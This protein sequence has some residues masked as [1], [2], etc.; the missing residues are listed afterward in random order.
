MDSTYIVRGKRLVT[1][2]KKGTIHDGA[3]AIENGKIKAIG[4]WKNMKHQY[5]DFLVMDYSNHVIT[6]SLVDCHTHLLEFAPTS[7]YPV[8]PETHFHAGRAILL[9]ALSAGITAIGE[10]VCGHPLC[11][12]S[13][14]DYR[15]MS[16]DFPMD[17]SFAAASISIG[18]EKLA[19]FASV[20]KSQSLRKE[21]LVNPQIVRSIAM[22]SD[23]PGENIFIN[24]TPANFTINEV[25]RA[26]EIIYSLDE[27]KQIT[28]I[29]HHLGKQIGAHVAGKEGIK[30]ALEAQIDVCH[31]VHGITEELMNTAAE[32]GTKVVA[33]PMG[34]THLPPNA[35]EE[36]LSLVKKGIP[37]SI[38]TDAYLPPY[39]GTGWLPFTDPSLKGPDVLML[40]ASPSMVLMKHNGFDENDILALITANPAELMGKGQQYGRLQPGMD[41][42]FIVSTGVPG[43]EITDVK[44]IKSVYYKGVKVIE[45][46]NNE[47]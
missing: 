41:A 43:L 23:Y 42:S 36:I 28:D 11:D 29:Y 25:P 26:G 16:A 37:V 39:M 9:K 40:I 27:L 30:L 2:S 44:D 47:H 4:L 19:H 38:A 31:H 18:F 33:T 17:I 5:P 3:M 6:P 20:T 12:F 32:Q 24:A 8:T 15:R 21:D 35:P 10:Q 46:G 13:M 14:E 34:G 22:E 45:R 7:L 1:V